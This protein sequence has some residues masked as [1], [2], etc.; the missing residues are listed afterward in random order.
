MLRIITL[1]L[2]GIRS[3]WRK[4]VLPWAS[5]QNADIICLQE[6]KAQHADL[7]EE[8]QAPDGFHAYY[9]C[10]E[11]KGYSGVG[12]WCRKKPERVSDMLGSSEFDAEGRYLRA[13]FGK[14][15]IV[16]LYQPSGS[17]SESRQEAKYRF[18]AFIDPHLRALA[19]SGQE[20]IVCADWNIAHQEI[21]LRN[22]RSNRKNSGFLPAERAWVSRLLDD[23]GWC[24]V[25][26]QLH[27]TIGEEGYTW[28]SNRGQAWANNVGWRLDY[29]LATAAIAATATNAA[30]YKQQRFSD[31]APLTIDYNFD[32]HG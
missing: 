15:S 14:L 22:W 11:K 3:A 25:Y 20:V 23:G 32:L 19:R 16:S 8:M 27:P 28:W 2:N 5:A 12:L 10:A 18:M 17:S 9:R 21:D 4:G 26:R 6:L 30:V 7:S 24:D 1:N 13:D 29:Q 31:H